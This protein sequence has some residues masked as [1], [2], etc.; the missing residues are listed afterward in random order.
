[1]SKTIRIKAKSV[2]EFRDII[3]E[4]RLIYN[5]TAD[6]LSQLA[7]NEKTSFIKRKLIEHLTHDDNNLS[8]KAMQWLH[9]IVTGESVDLELSK[10]TIYKETGTFNFSIDQEKI[11]LKLKKDNSNVIPGDDYLLKMLAVYIDYF[12]QLTSILNEF[13]FKMKY[14]TGAQQIRPEVTAL[15]DCSD[16]IE[17]IIKELCLNTAS[18]AK[19]KLEIKSTINDPLARLAAI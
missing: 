1:M 4:Y 11:Y 2:Q 5:S 17:S 15:R 13:G 6:E 16:K 8:L 9:T 3:N 18:R 7:E 12:N 14:R 19:M 10:E